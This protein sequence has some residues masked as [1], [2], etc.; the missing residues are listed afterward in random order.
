M[1]PKKN[2]VEKIGVDEVFKGG[3][4]FNSPSLTFK[5]LLTNKFSIPRVSF[6]APKSIAKLAVKRNLLRRRGYNALKKY[7]SDFPSGL[8]GVFVFKKYED[9]VLIIENEIKNILSEIN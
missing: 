4:F 5:F 3:R 8:V 7:I 2:R 6:I 1:L 9:D